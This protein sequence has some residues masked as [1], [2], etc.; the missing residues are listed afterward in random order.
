MNGTVILSTFSRIVTAEIFF[1]IMMAMTASGI[2][3]RRLLIAD[4]LI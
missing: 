3:E 2:D 1:V 4:F